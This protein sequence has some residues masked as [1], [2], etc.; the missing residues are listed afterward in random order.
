VSPEV[1]VKAIPITADQVAQRDAIWSEGFADY[2]RRTGLGDATGPAA[3]SQQSAGFLVGADQAMRS[4][5]ADILFGLLGGASNTQQEFQR[6]SNQQLL[7]NFVANFTQ[8]Q[9]FPEL[10][11]APGQ[12]SFLYPFPDAH[13]INT[14][15]KQRLTGP[16]FGFTS[17]FFKGGFFPTLSLGE[18][19]ST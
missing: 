16:S 13:S 1:P 6:S 7:T 8:S 18:I 12:V 19:S 17:S 4:G 15:E 11:P 9:L 5:D 2:E 10:P 14:D 3:R